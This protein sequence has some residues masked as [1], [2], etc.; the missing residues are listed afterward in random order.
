[1]NRLSKL[2]QGMDSKQI[3]L[4][5]TELSRLRDYDISTYKH[6]IDVGVISAYIANEMRFNRGVIEKCYI[7]G[8]L[9]DIGKAEIDKSILNKPG[10]LTDIEFK[11]M[12]KHSKLGYCRL[13]TSSIIDSSIRLAVLEH[14][15]QENGMGYPFGIVQ[16]NI[17]SKIV[18][19]A[20]VYSAITSKRSYKEAKSKEYALKEIKL[21]IGES[22]DREVV[23]ALEQCIDS[24]EVG[25]GFEDIE[26]DMLHFTTNMC[27]SNSNNYK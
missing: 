18:H 2:E 5:N 6:S 17:V 21:H 27:S 20:D 26:V 10:R 9:H 7:A 12:Q 24:C 3:E 13:A 16:K 15:E 25:D 11:Q 8:L 14:H 22:F 23:E 19:V 1:M 4:I